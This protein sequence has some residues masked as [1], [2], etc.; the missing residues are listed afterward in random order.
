MGLKG[1]E[2]FDLKF[3]ISFKGEMITFGVFIK[4]RVGYPKQ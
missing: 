4:E 3:C 1:A 2:V